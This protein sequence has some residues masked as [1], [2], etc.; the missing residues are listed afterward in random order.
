MD[1]VD[2]QDALQVSRNEIH[3]TS[4]LQVFI[5]S[6]EHLSASLL[7]CYYSVK[8]LQ[9]YGRMQVDFSPQTR[10]TLL[11]EMWGEFERAG[12]KLTAAHYGTFL[13]VLAD[14]GH[15]DFSPEA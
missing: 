2:E 4:S 14:N 6:V 9:T 7:S 5:Y 13:T 10:T 1:K 12:V 8:V 3:R 15:D 11:K